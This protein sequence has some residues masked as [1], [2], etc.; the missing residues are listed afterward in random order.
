MDRNQQGGVEYAQSVA[1]GIFHRSHPTQYGAVPDESVS[2]NFNDLQNPVPASVYYDARWS[3][4]WGNQTHCA[5]ITDDSYRPRL[6]IK[7]SV[8]QS[9]FPILS[10]C[11]QPMLPNP[12]VS[13]LP[14]GTTLDVPS[15]P[16]PTSALPGVAI[17]ALSSP[18][19]AKA[20][21]TTSRDQAVA[22]HQLLPTPT[23]KTSHRQLP[24]LRPAERKA[25]EDGNQG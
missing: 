12:R 21:I 11:V 22:P 16:Q 15:V 2:L 19:V 23:S 18:T 13:M 4:C 1:K 17:P 24:G 9:L 6:G 3:E 8:W 5:T 25:G 10:E 14:L 20:G 7:N